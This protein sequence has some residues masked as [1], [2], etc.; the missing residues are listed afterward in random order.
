[1]AKIIIII[2]LI[3]LTIFKCNELKKETDCSDKTILNK[4]KIYFDMDGNID[5]IVCLLLLLFF[6]NI[7]LVGVAITPGD[8]DIPPAME[9]VSKIIYKKGAKI[10]IVASNIKGI[11]PFPQSF[12]DLT[13]KALVLPTFLNIEYRKDNEIDM[14]ASEHMYITSKKIFHE[15]NEKLSFLVT[16]PPSTLVKAI[17]DHPDMKNYIE[18]I[19]WMG[20]A[21]DV[22]GN[23]PNSPY[24]EYNAFWDPPSVK[25][26]FEFGIN[27]KIFSLDSTNY[28]PIDK[29][30]LS[31]LAKISDKYNIANLANELYAISY[32][33][34]ITGKDTY[35]AWDSLATCYVGLNELISF[36]EEEVDII[37]DKNSNINETQE[38]RIFKKKGSAHFV[39]IAEKMSPEA[40]KKFYDFFVES[41]KYNF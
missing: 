40:L 36:R 5:D 20:G 24:A 23:V 37:L 33:I 41:L 17:N 31:R 32:F 22:M 3:V 29:N 34:D 27:I 10:P 16:G 18:E 21:V 8:C 25:K 38:G 6:Q 14:E 1:M 7:E 15:N 2:F 35:Y 19:V 30:F 28:V 4:R 26:L 9:T 39:K 12:K 13:I 11:N